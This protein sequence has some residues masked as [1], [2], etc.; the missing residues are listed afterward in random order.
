MSLIQSFFARFSRPKVDQPD[1]FSLRLD[2]IQ[3]REKRL[4]ARGGVFKAYAGHP[5]G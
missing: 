3:R 2:R 1:A 4:R 5:A